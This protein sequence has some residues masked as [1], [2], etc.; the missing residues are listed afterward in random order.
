MNRKILTIVIGIALLMGAFFASKILSVKEPRKKGKEDKEKL[1]TSVVVEKVE[2]KTIPI[3]VNATGSLVAKNRLELYAEVQGIMKSAHKEFKAGVTFGKGEALV[4]IDGSEY[5]ASLQAKKSELLSLIG[6]MM[7]DL[8]LDFPDSFD[9]WQTYLNEFDLNKNIAELPSPKDTKE[10]LFV[11]GK[12]IYT[13]FYTIKNM[14]IK[15][16]KYHLRAPFYG[17]V[18]ESLVNSGTLVRTGQKIGEF[19]DPSSYE[20]EVSLTA[21]IAEKLNTGDVVEVR[22][23]EEGISWKGYVA[24]VNGKIDQASQTTKVFVNVKGKG[25]KEGKYLRANIALSPI[26]NAL[27]IKRNLLIEENK[28]YIVKEKTL[29]LVTVETVYFGDG[30]VVIKGLENGTQLLSK[31][32]PGLYDGMEVE[33]LN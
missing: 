30:D 6:S 2:N 17:V 20:M 12:N 28:V 33:V 22:S 18:T 8:R 15:W 1:I 27:K 25:L 5:Y 19:I 7:A 14:E 29:K 13:T 11:S 31:S 26:E 32:M 4:T 24:R 10:K 23:L 16:S 3:E 21:V 9:E